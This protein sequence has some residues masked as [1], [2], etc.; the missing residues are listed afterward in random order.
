M[1]FIKSIFV[2][3]QHTMECVIIMNLTRNPGTAGILKVLIDD[4]ELDQR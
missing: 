3:L 2:Y 4:S 1:G